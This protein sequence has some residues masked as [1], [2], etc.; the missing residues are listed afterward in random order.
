MPRGS[1]VY[2]GLLSCHQTVY[3]AC[4]CERKERVQKVLLDEASISKIKTVSWLD[5]ESPLCMIFV[6]PG[7][8]AEDAPESASEDG[9]D[10]SLSLSLAIYL[11]FADM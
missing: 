1:S 8:I 4:F 9:V 5:A 7:E 6:C 2:L 11:D 10:F 3:I